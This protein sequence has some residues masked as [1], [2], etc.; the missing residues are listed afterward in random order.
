VS[1]RPNRRFL[2]IAAALVIPAAWLLARDTGSDDPTL[3]A[4]ATRGEFTVTVR[5]AGELGARESMEIMAP[6]GARQAQIYQ[7]RISSLVPEGTVVDS[8]DVVAELDRSELAAKQAEAALALEK[9][10]A[11]YE[12]A[13][14][15]S[16][17]NLSQARE[18]IRSKELAL[19]EASLEKEQSVYEPPT[20]QRQAEINLERADRALNQGKADY[21]TKTE[22]SK[23]KMREVAADVERERNKLTIIQEVM[24]GFTVKAPAPGMVI[25]EKEWNGRKKAAG[26][27]VNSW[28]PTVATLPDLSKMESITYVNEIDVRNVAVGQPVQITF[29]ADPTKQSTGTVAKVANV[30]EQR[31]NTDAKVFEVRITVAEA[32]T[33]L[34][35]GMTTGNAIQTL[36]QEDVLFVPIE[37]LNS[38]DGVPYV[39]QQSG[40]SARKQEVV[41]G[42]MND[43]EVI[44]LEGL[45]EDDRV[46]LIPPSNRDGMSL[47]R[48][49]NSPVR[50]DSAATAGGDTALQAPSGAPAEGPE[51]EPEPEPVP[52]AEPADSTP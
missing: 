29:D 46:L 5:T 19:E 33:T 48:L 28:D 12:Q 9:A 35:P 8:G 13:M 23:A 2:I 20:V 25:Y 26:S 45:E 50:S 27:M 11:V 39:F 18:D 34:R 38:Q 16:A 40:G 14:L 37:A 4:R 43:D 51:T 6:A 52:E 49:E 42:A 32:D 47:N 15:D 24:T 21:N 7:M 36:R 3:V 41:T 44:I 30:G 10:E 1:L 17:L 22:Q 31:P